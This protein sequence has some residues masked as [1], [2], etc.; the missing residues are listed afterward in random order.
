MSWIDALGKLGEIA[1]SIVLIEKRVEELEKTNKDQAALI[2]ELRK[3]ISSLTARVAVLEEN[4]KTVAA[5]V[6]LALAEFGHRW[7]SE[8]LKKQLEEMR[9]QPR[10]IE[11]SDKDQKA[12]PPKQ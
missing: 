4:R 7:E 2:V 12:L 3:D 11:T 8:Q 5:E 1:K 10:N 6:K 9:Q